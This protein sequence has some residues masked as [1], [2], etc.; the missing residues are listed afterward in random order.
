MRRPSRIVL[1]I[2][3]KSS[4]SSTMSA[5]SRA[6]SVPRPPIAMPI[7][8]YL[9]AGASFTP[10]PVIATTSP[11]ERSAL[12]ICIFSRGS[13]REKI[14]TSPSFSARSSSSIFSSSSP[15]IITCSFSPQPRP[16][17]CAIRCAVT[18]LSPV[19]ITTRTP[20]PPQALIDSATFS[21]GGSIK[22]ASPARFRE[23]SSISSGISFMSSL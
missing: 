8:A 16:T 1:T 2:V 6:T 22:A 17:S 23:H 4:S 18:L 10:S 5:A 19:I 12:T 7:S 3:E 13:M 9:R 15:L 20:A 21:R 11:R 14:V